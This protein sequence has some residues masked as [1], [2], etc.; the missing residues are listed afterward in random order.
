[1]TPGFFFSCADLS[2]LAE[3][4]LQVAVIVN[5]NG[6]LFGGEPAGAAG[7]GPAAMWGQNPWLALPGGMDFVAVAR[8]FGVPGERVT[9][10]EELAPAIRRALDA[11]GPYLLG[12]DHRRCRVLRGH[13]ARACHR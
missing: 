7:V 9:T 8:G 4:N 3:R 10:V 2:T 6:G 12:R 1:M 5:N 11:D 13:D